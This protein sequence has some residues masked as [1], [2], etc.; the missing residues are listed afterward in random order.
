MKNKI[1]IG[2]AGWSY[3]DWKGVVYPPSANSKFDPLAY[4]A[5]FFDTIEINSS[6]YRPPTASTTKSWARRVAGNPDFTFTA[7]LHRVFTHERGKATAADRKDFH[8]GMEPL[9]EAGKLGA[10][11]L[12]FPWSF[13]NTDEERTYLERL[14]EQF[15]DYPLIV[16]VRHT[17]WNTPGIYEELEERGVGICNIDQPLFSRSIKP[18]ALTTSPLGYVRLHGRNYQS[19]FRDKAPRDERYNYLYSVDELDPWIA[20][21]KE[22]A[23][24]TKEAYVITN[25]HFLGKA[26]VNALEI[27]S[28]LEERKVKAPL[29]LFDKYPRLS[30]SAVPES[31][32]DQPDEPMLFT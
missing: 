28:T 6:F 25:N 24:Q 2:P 7:K 15:K 22:V 17:S 10:L 13:K 4:L 32:S 30:E 9:R 23:K 31:A 27:M 3:H 1:R 20:R 21:I 18:S 5:K 12:Q 19:W 29:P 16:E 26:V 11:L 14:I 8:E